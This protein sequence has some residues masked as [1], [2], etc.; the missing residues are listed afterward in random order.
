MVLIIIGTTCRIDVHRDHRPGHPD[1]HDDQQQQRPTPPLPKGAVARRS[2]VH[3]IMLTSGGFRG[4]A[5]SR[6]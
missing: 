2:P 1:D 4:K 3:P 5:A 6:L